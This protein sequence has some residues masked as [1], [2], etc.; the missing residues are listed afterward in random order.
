MPGELSLLHCEDFRDEAKQPDA[1]AKLIASLRQPNA[2]LGT[3]FAV[4]SLAQ[5]GP[6]A[7]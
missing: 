3:L 6:D 7:F 2:K 5:F 4:L 1:L